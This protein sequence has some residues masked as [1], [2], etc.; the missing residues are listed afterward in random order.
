MCCV[1]LIF[2]LDKPWKKKPAILNTAPT[3][4][5][6]IL[7]PTPVSPPTSKPTRSLPPGL[8]ELV[9]N[10]PKQE[11]VTNYDAVHAWWWI[12]YDDMLADMKEKGDSSGWREIEQTV[13]ES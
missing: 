6:P 8:A 13:R 3:K 9:Q 12:A 2:S 4:E 5:S 11:N 7:P 10:S 1:E